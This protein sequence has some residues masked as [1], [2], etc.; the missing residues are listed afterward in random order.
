[1]RRRKFLKRSMAGLA[2][3]PLG[4]AHAVQRDRPAVAPYVETIFHNGRMVTGKEGAETAQA[5]AVLA[6]KIVGIGTNDEIRALATPQTRLVDFEG[7]T[8]LP[9]FYDSHIHISTG[10]GPEVQAWNKLTSTQELYKAMRE[11]AAQLK[12]EDEWVYG[13]IGSVPLPNR[14]ELDKVVPDHPVVLT[15]G[16][17]VMSVNSLAL[18]K[19]GV[20]EGTPSPPG[21][22][23]VRD[24]NGRLTGIIEEIPAWR[25]ILRVVPPSSPDDKAIVA[26]LGDQLKTLLSLGITTANVAGVRPF[27]LDDPY[28][29]RSMT[30]LGPLQD[31]YEQSGDQLPRLRVQIRIRPGYEY[32]DD[33]V[34]VGA[35]A[36]IQELESLGFHT[37][38]GN[39]RLKLSAAKMSL[40]GRGG[41]RIPP[42]VFYRVAKRAHELGWQLGVHTLGDP[43]ITVAVETME[44]ILMELPKSGHRHYLHHAL[45]LPSENILKKM[46][47]LKLGVSTEP[48]FILGSSSNAQTVRGPHRTYLN[49]AIPLG[50]GSDMPVWEAMNRDLTPW[51]PVFGI[52]AAMTRQ[53]RDGT[54]RN[55]GERVTLKEAIRFYT[56][57]TAYLNFDE[58]TVGSLERGKNADMVVLSE[59][60]FKVEVDRIKDLKV[61]KTIVAG[62][63]LYSS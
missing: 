36:A 60:I 62:E 42:E 5:V 50:Y 47:N 63:I 14:W 9:G 48:R 26:Y 57:G 58:R 12:S 28:R 44:R 4:E 49:H 39:E 34:N 25:R 16:A 59:D 18:R 32:H 8:V 1:M 22:N 54:V 6:G 24:E 21:G 46:A 2:L 55:P 10:H 40:D 43:A 30:R 20:T 45:S 13:Y 53:N 37:G 38:F 33:P 41:F 3:W 7:A 27:H 56:L 51:S 17:H 15:R 35:A 61:K 23:I 52:W 19:A 11:R 31:L 29:Y